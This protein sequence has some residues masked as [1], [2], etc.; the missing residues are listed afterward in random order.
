MERAEMFRFVELR[1]V[2]SAKTRRIHPLELM[3]LT[4]PS[5]VALDQPLVARE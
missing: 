1:A 4:L 3:R 5:W 2:G